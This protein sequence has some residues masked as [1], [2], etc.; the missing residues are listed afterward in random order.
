[1]QNPRINLISL[2]PLF[3][4]LLMSACSSG[5]KSTSE[6]SSPGVIPEHQLKTLQRAGEVEGILLDKDL[7]RQQQIDQIQNN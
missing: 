6:N 4:I 2:L 7:Q 3:I 5:D 1:M